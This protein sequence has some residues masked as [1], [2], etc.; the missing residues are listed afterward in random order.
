MPRPG[1]ASVLDGRSTRLASVLDLDDRCETDGW[2]LAEIR[3]TRDGVVEYHEFPI[4]YDR[5]P[6]RDE[7]LGLL[8]RCRHPLL[9]HCQ[10]GADR[11][12]LASA[13][14]L[15]AFRGVPPDRAFRRAFS[16]KYGHVPIGGIAHLHKPIR[17]Y[18]DWLRAHGLTHHPNRFRDRVKPEYKPLS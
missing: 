15:M 5:R 18:R 1:P 6:S 3:E 14:Y 7:L 16:L 8:D 4:C 12:A 10:D 11:T 13:I 2:S 9:I 17:E